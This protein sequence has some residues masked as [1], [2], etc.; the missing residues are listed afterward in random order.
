MVLQRSWKP[1]GA[2]LW[3]FESLALRKYIQNKGLQPLVLFYSGEV[4]EWLKRLPWKGSIPARVSWVRIPP[5]PQNVWKNL[6]DLCNFNFLHKYLCNISVCFTFYWHAWFIIFQF[7]RSLF[8]SCKSISILS[9]K[10][11]L[12]TTSIDSIIFPIK[13]EYIL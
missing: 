11:H 2:S 5:S 7:S 6:Q 8:L 12:S 13:K 9:I 10:L 4:L 1:P 3:G